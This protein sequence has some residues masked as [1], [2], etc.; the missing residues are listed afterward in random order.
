MAGSIFIPDVLEENVN[1]IFASNAQRPTLPVVVAPTQESR[2]QAQNLIRQELIVVGCASL[3]QFN[4]DFDSS[5]VRPEAQEGFAAFARLRQKHERCP[6]TIFGHADP[7]GRGTDAE[8][9]RYNHVL[10]DRRARA[11]FG[12][13]TRDERVWE[14]LMDDQQGAV[15]DVW[16]KRITDTMRASVG[17]SGASAPRRTLIGLYMDF[18]RG[19]GF[20]AL[21][22]N[23]FLGKGKQKA[24]LQGCSSFNPQLLMSKTQQKRFD[25]DKATKEERDAANEPNRRVMIFLFAEG[26]AINPALWPCPDTPFDERPCVQRQWL[27]GADRRKTL[28]VD[29]RR[30]FGREVPPEGRLLEPPNQALADE[31]AQEEKT[32]G[33]RFYHGIALHSPC[34]RDLRL[35]GVQLLLDP[36]APDSNISTGLPLGKVALANRRFAATLGTTPDA[37][38]VRGK[39]TEN[40][41]VVLPL[42]DPRIAITLRIDAFDALTPPKPPP[43]PAPGSPDQPSPTP[44]PPAAPRPT[45]D[46]ARFDDEETFLVLTLAAGALSPV[47]ARDDSSLFFDEDFDLPVKPVTPAERELAAMQRLYNLGFGTGNTGGGQFSNWTPEMRER[48]VKAFQKASG[49][50]E[51]GVVDDATAEALFT[52]HGS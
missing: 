20:P 29:H 11:V 52:A 28:F 39:T 5:F 42:F 7:T 38:T 2:I 14:K 48:F 10:S 32:F 17:E 26:T 23:D 36:P 27:N 50:T 34:E 37:P 9:L 8:R 1:G 19:P 45:T 44:T 51:S 21:T 18:L 40:G 43:S 13:L 30:R 25:G 33:C 15:G 6:M 31:L 24:T 3:K 4:F 49:V 41:M 16:G 12:V 46:S 22:A 47:R 35:W